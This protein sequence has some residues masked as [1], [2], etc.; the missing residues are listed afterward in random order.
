MKRLRDLSDILQEAKYYLQVAFENEGTNDLFEKAVR[1]DDNNLYFRDF[2]GLNDTTI[3]GKP[4]QNNDD[5][6]FSTAQAI[7]III[8]TWTY[9]RPDTKT[10]KWKDNATQRVKDL[11]NS[12]V[13][14]L[15]ANIFNTDLKVANAFFSGSV[16]GLSS[17]P[18]WY[19]A[20]YNVYLVNGTSFDPNTLPQSAL[21]FKY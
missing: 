13:N 8:S 11:L 3:F 6:L 15:K 9:Q 1:V 2:L 10:L 21:G 18:F 14:W 7:N 20:N 19:P 5:A 16:K 4:E 17:L 12:A